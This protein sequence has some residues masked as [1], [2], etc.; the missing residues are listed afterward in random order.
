L[1]NSGGAGTKVSVDCFAKDIGELQKFPG[2]AGG[3]LPG[4]AAFADSPDSL[5]KLIRSLILNLENAVSSILILL[6]QADRQL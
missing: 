4:R 3:Q 1:S 2:S 5:G 6:E